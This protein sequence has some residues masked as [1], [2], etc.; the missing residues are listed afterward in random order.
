MTGSS[1]TFVTRYPASSLAFIAWSR[2]KAVLRYA[3][4]LSGSPGFRHR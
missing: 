1:S 4:C 3:M 2:S